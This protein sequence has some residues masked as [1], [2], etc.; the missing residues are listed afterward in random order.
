MAEMNPLWDLIQA[1][2]DDPKHRYRVV[3][4]DLSRETGVSEQVLSKWKAKPVLPNPL[5]LVAFAA[6][7]GIPYESLLTA[8]LEGRGYLPRL[9][10]TRIVLPK[11]FKE[12][13]VVQ[14]PS[15]GD[16][17]REQEAELQVRSARAKATLLEQLSG[18]A[19]GV[20]VRSR[21]MMA[22]ADGILT[23]E[24]RREIEELTQRADE[25]TGTHGYR[26][27]RDDAA[28]TT[29]IATAARSQVAASLER[30][31]PKDEG[32]EVE[33]EQDGES[34]QGKVS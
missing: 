23:E 6:G 17:V 25:T 18:G 28:G 8:V 7:T 27:R 16:S 19:L 30:R 29:V 1:Y 22:Q 10:G 26:R 24:D 13:L 2:M 14:A 32:P 15:L 4:A 9:S 31:L 33:T 21:A 11:A 34:G 5:H 20:L 12:Q 3:A